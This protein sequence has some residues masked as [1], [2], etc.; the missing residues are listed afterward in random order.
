[1]TRLIEKETKNMADLRAEKLRK[2]MTNLTEKDKFSP[3]GYWKV[4]KAAKVNKKTAYGTAI[5]TK[6]NGVEIKGDGAIREAYKEEF[7]YR[8]RS[9]EP[10][11][12]WE[13]YVLETNEIIRNWLK[14]EDDSG[15]S[16]PFKFQELWE[17]IKKLKEDKSPGCDQY[18]PALFTQA[19]IGLLLSLLELF[20]TVKKNRVTP[21]QWNMMKITVIYKQK[22]S[23]KVL[24][25]YR[26]IFLALI[27][28]KI[29]E[30]LIKKRINENLENINILQAGSR[31][32][33][34]PQ[35]QVFLLRGCVDHYVSQKKPLYITAYDYEQ[36]FD[37][38]WVEDCIMSLKELG[39]SKEMLQLI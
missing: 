14:S 3:N 15:S 8:L 5:V 38:L 12:G 25:N 23:K 16:P 29:F 17:V 7:E 37:S 6:E 36:A 32:N 11:P 9:R 19:G 4:K 35:D 20:N 33:R 26:G 1:M 27:I 22:G 30:G 39:I 31:S 2:T 28:S 13:N 18:P 24:K 21:D 10:A 34:G